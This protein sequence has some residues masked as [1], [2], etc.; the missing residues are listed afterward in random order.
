MQEQANFWGREGF[1]PRFLQTCPKKPPKKM[2]SK[3]KTTAFRFILGAFFQIKPLQ[4]TFLP[5]CPISPKL[6][7]KN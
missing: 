1:L 6:L 7:E 2:P 3:K 4:A 5:N